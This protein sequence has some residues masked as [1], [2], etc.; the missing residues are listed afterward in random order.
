MIGNPFF[1][2]ATTISSF[3]GDITAD[4]K[5]SVSDSSASLP[6]LRMSHDLDFT[7]SDD[8]LDFS[9]ENEFRKSLENLETGEV[10]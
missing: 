5:F 6:F 3:I 9:L 7:E 2:L 4:D 1:M 8:R 10:D